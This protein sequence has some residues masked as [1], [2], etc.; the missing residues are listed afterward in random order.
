L[1]PEQ[2]RKARGVYLKHSVNRAMN[3]ATVAVTVVGRCAHSPREAQ[4]IL[5]AVAPTPMH[6][7][8]T[9][10]LLAAEAVLNARTF[11]HAARLASEEARPISD[12]R[13]SA[14]YR[15]EMVRVLT[16]RALRAVLD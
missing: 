4:V 15:R 12:V 14:E 5:S 7:T 11:P 9:E 1:V 6:A 2:S 10:Q 13:A 16:E 8:R 3:L